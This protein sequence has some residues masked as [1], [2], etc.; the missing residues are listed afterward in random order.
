MV[1]KVVMWVEDMEVT[2]EVEEVVEE[3]VGSQLSCTSDAPGTTPASRC[4]NTRGSQGAGRALVTSTSM[5]FTC[6][7]LLLLFGTSPG[8][9]QRD[10]TGVDCPTLSSCIQEVLES[11][12]CCPSC[13]RTGCTCEGYQY[14]DCVNAGFQN[15]KVPEGDAYFVD[16]GSTE[17]SCPEGGGRISCHYISCPELPANCIETTEPG[18]ACV[19]CERVGCVHGGQ[20]YDAGHSFHPDPCRVCHCPAEGGELMCYPVPDCDPRTA[21][22]PASPPPTERSGQHGGDPRDGQRRGQG[23]RLPPPP[24]HRLPPS[25]NLPLFKSPPLDKM[26]LEEEEHDDYDY[27]PTDAPEFEDGPL[28]FPS[29]ASPSGMVVPLSRGADGAGRTSQGHGHGRRNKLELRERYGIREHGTD[30]RVPAT[31]S[32]RMSENGTPR[33][34]HG[35]NGQRL[36][37]QHTTHGQLTPQAVID[38]PVH[39]ESMTDRVVFSLHKPPGGENLPPFFQSNAESPSAHTERD[40]EDTD[41]QRSVLPPNLPEGPWSGPPLF[42]LVPGNQSPWVHPKEEEHPTH[43]LSAVDRPFHTQSTLRSPS[44]SQSTLAPDAYYPDEYNAY[45]DEDMEA[46]EEEEGGMD[47]EREAALVKRRRDGDVRAWLSSTIW[48]FVWLLSLFTQPVYINGAVSASSGPRT[49]CLRWADAEGLL[50]RGPEM[51]VRA[52]AL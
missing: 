34:S 44:A 21:R 16:Y 28:G 47:H 2:M 6:A 36:Q 35:N 31:D 46:E 45:D 24:R 23:D 19:Q 3:V 39:A 15:G 11:G 22:L 8:L 5:P 32:P 33:T 13:V 25:G 4:T 42:H 37:P 27:E 9:C 40:S 18:D 14:Y 48:V 30:Y 20:K 43:R 10:C 17:C 49:R 41:S 52:P 26:A 51:G 29:L 50:C 1:V 7:L 12:A 38:R